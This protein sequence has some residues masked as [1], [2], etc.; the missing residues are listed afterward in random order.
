MSKGFGSKIRAS[1]YSFEDVLQE[2]YK[3][4]L[5]RNRGKCPFDPAKS[6]FGH[7][8][9]MVAECVIRNHHR[10]AQRVSVESA[11]LRGVD[12]ELEDVGESSTL[13]YEGTQGVVDLLHGVLGSFKERP[14]DL[15]IAQDVVRGYLDGRLQAGPKRV[16]QEI[17]RIS[18]SRP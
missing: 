18:L 2:V 12:G 1:G 11:G 6:S 15:Q 17:R 5:V 14:R 10:Y 8:V 9:W 16:L 13:G 7:Y 3:G 4:L